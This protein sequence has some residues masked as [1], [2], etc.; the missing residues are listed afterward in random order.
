MFVY[1]EWHRA[2]VFD[3]RTRSFNSEVAQGVG[4]AG[5]LTDTALCLLAATLT[6]AHR[7]NSSRYPQDS[8]TSMRSY[9]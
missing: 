8:T 9:R 6:F 1:C 3:C 2:F 5:G 4:A 7:F